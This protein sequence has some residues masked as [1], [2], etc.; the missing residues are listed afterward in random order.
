MIGKIRPIAA[1][2]AI[3]CC[4]A[5]SG[6]KSTSGSSGSSGGSSGGSVSVQ[7]Q[8]SAPYVGSSRGSL[9][10]RGDDGPNNNSSSEIP[11]ADAEGYLRLAA[12]YADHVRINNAQP[13]LCQSALDSYNFEV[14]ELDKLNH[15]DKEA[16]KAMLTTKNLVRDLTCESSDVGGG[17]H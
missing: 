1:A 4:F 13:A 5:L 17:K 9:K 14:G 15:G 16:T 3:A 2:V 6:C 7:T 12:Q 11:P 10:D 8:S